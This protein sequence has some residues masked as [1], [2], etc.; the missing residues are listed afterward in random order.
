MKGERRGA[1]REIARR[2]RPVSTIPLELGV[3]AKA[4]ARAVKGQ[5]PDRFP[6]ESPGGRRWWL[7]TRRQ[8]QSSGNSG[9]PAPVRRR[10][11]NASL[12]EGRVIRILGMRA[13]RRYKL[14]SESRARRFP[15]VLCK[16][17]A[18]LLPPAPGEPR[19]SPL[20][21][22]PNRSGA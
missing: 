3:R 13:S 17:D 5:K 2:R 12:R 18:H 8:F 1:N 7:P 15:A 4:T 21:P 16:R 19:R 6:S 14:P 22:S 10:L 11:T 9:P 20:A